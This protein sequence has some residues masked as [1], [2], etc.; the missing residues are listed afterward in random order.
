MEHGVVGLASRI[1]NGGKNIFPLKEGITCE[2]FFIG[3][4]ARQEIQDVG[5]AETKTRMQGRPPHFP[6]STVIL[7]SRSLLINLKPEMV[8]AK[9][10]GRPD[11]RTRIAATST[12]PIRREEE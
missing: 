7:L 2:N 11:W 3:S 8:C 12:E 10:Q 5:D 9:E 1:F 6:S 4:P